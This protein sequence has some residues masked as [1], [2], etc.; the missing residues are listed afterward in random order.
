MG[1]FDRRKSQKMR[2]SRA[3]AKKK[4]REQRVAEETRA[5]RKGKK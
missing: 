1:R 4:E 5:S 2:R 3:Q